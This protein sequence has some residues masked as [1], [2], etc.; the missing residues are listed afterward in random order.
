MAP[1]VKTASAASSAEFPLWRRDNLFFLNI[2]RN[3]FNLTTGAE[4]A[5]FLRSNEP[6][7]CRV[8]KGEADIAGLAPAVLGELFPGISGIPFEAQL[9]EYNLRRLHAE[10]TACLKSGNEPSEALCEN[11]RKTIADGW[12]LLSRLRQRYNELRAAKTA[13]KILE[14]KIDR[15]AM[16]SLEGQLYLYDG[17]YKDAA[18]AFAKGLSHLGLA[19]LAELGP[20]VL[21]T[22]MSINLWFSHEMLPAGDVEKEDVSLSLTEPEFVRIVCDVVFVTGDTRLLIN[23]SEAYAVNALSGPASELLCDTAEMLG[24]PAPELPQHQPVGYQTALGEIPAFA[25]ALARAQAVEARRRDEREKKLAAR[26]DVNG[27]P[28]GSL[29]DDATVHLPRF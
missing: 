28:L 17:N 8:R 5:D 16:R 19:D 10:K 2:I 3:E 6:A 4:V 18:S 22:R 24:I 25:A 15:A 21:F 7:V 20:R 12:K 13:E 26:C 11:L 9:M 14:R 1:K 27:K 29:P 23:V